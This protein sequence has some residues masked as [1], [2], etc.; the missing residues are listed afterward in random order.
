MSVGRFGWNLQGRGSYTITSAGKTWPNSLSMN[1]IGGTYTL[2]DGLA[3]N[4]LNVTINHGTFTTNNYAVSCNALSLVN[5]DTTGNFG[6][7]T[8]TATGT[9]GTV[10][11]CTSSAVVNAGSATF[12]IANASATTRTV[13]WSR[14]M[15]TL[16]YTVAG[17]TGTLNMG[18][19]GG[20][21]LTTLNFSDASNA[22]T[23]QFVSGTTTTVTNFNVNGTAGKLM[24]ISASTPGSP[25]I[26]SKS[27]G[28]VSC[29]YVS[30]QDSSASGGAT[31]YAGSNSTNVS[32]N[33]GWIFT[34]SS[35]NF[36]QM[37]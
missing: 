11:N 5:A 14:V 8:V 34:A 10:F 26:L 32:G 6:T 7:S 22:R 20:P 16:T 30:V 25:A 33:S 31:W 1:A 15:G 23:L 3:V 19:G 35:D 21:T 13:Q 27:S 2:Q 28:S 24:T 12:I 18:V 9:S 4:A 36:L 37:F 29:D 17:S